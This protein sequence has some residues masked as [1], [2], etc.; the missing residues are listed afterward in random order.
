MHL[1]AA[2]LEIKIISTKYLENTF[3]IK[4]SKNFRSSIATVDLKFA[5]QLLAFILMFYFIQ[6]QCSKNFFYDQKIRLT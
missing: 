5:N 4:L 2:G 1:Y 6:T 3:L